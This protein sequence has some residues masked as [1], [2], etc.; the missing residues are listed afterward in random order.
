MQIAC[1]SITEI[2]HRNQKSNHFN[3]LAVMIRNLTLIL[4]TVFSLNL[5]AQESHFA[6]YHSP[7]MKVINMETKEELLSSKEDYKIQLKIEM[8]SS[9]KEN[10]IK[11]K[12]GSLI[13]KE[14]FSIKLIELHDANYK[15][16]KYYY[17]GLMENNNEEP[18]YFS[19]G[20]YGNEKGIYLIALGSETKVMLFTDLTLLRN[21][22]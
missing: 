8:D 9:K 1:I 22:R 10:Q 21:N 18:I 4:F 7:M 14:H 12:R 6:E 17:Q 2:C 15:E 19:V 16:G 5:L 11:F 20:I 3:F 13:I